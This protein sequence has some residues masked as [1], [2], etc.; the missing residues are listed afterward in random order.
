M[1]DGELRDGWSRFAWCPKDDHRDVR[2]GSG[3]EEGSSSPRGAEG[4][5][6]AGTG[7]REPCA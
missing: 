5:N 1:G 7:A 3:F 6:V 4:P 2:G